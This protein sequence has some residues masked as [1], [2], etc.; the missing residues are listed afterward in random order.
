MC[1][2]KV[3][4]RAAIFQRELCEA[5]LRGVRDQ[6]HQDERLRTGDIGDIDLAGVML[7]G[8]NEILLFAKRL[9]KTVQNRKE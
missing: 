4:R 8:D 1:S 2:G 9:R 3:A 5:V 7:D 6:L